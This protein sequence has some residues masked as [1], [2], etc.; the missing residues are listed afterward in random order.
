VKLC[1]PKQATAEVMSDGGGAVSVTLAMATMA[2][3]LLTFCIS[4]DLA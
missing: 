3:M 4:L 2:L 1:D